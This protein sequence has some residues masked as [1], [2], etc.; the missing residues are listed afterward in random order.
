MHLRT[1]ALGNNSTSSNETRA[2]LMQFEDI[3][4]VL[5]RLHL[6]DKTLLAVVAPNNTFVAD[7][8]LT[9]DLIHAAPRDGIAQ[10]PSSGH[11]YQVLQLPIIDHEKH[12]IGEVVMARR[13]DGMLML[14]PHARLVFVLAMLAALGVAIGTTLRARRITGAR[15]A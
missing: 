14:F 12:E 8:G 5:D 7:A 4:E 9:E 2:I 10:V 3:T 1:L 11:D 13:V 15:V 6:D